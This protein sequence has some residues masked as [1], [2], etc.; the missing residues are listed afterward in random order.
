MDNTFRNKE[1]LEKS[2]GLP[3]IGTIIDYSEEEVKSSNVSTR[4][5]RNRSSRRIFK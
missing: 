2:L 3:V 5:G 4:S 1:D